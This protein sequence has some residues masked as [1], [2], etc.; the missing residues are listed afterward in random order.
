MLG[1]AIQLPFLPRSWALPVAAPLYRLESLNRAEQRRH[2]AAHEMARFCARSNG[3]D[4]LVG[5]I[6]TKANLI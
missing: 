2:K 4:T 6:Y 5:R 1:F 3:R